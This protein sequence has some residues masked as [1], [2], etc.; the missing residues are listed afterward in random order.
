M[1]CIIAKLLAPQVA[2]LMALNND[3]NAGI[4]NDR[5]SGDVFCPLKKKA[6]PSSEIRKARHRCSE[7]F[8]TVHSFWTFKYLPA[9]CVI[10]R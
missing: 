1:V 7:N 4:V 5:S 9:S 2:N 3:A 10:F 6:L 8:A